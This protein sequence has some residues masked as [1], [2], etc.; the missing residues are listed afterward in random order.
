MP[1][2][3]WE[4]LR[5]GG[6]LAILAVGACVLPALEAAE[7][8]AAEGWRIGVVNAR[9]VKPLDATVLAET[10]AANASLITA[11]EGVLRGGFGDAVLAHL[12]EHGPAGVVVERAGI[13]DEFVEHAPQALLRARFGI[14]AAGLAARARRLLA[15]KN[16][17]AG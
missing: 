1:I 3:S 15:S 8:L 7:A 14:N 2:G 6:D 10:A 17:A 16:A 12:A 5:P 4:V 9:F 11:E 13:P